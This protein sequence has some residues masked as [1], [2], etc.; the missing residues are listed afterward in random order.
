M[1]ADNF[2]SLTGESELPP[3]LVENE[4][5]NSLMA[6]AEKLVSESQEMLDEHQTG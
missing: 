1:Y 3:W 6:E 4:Q 2:S 5:F